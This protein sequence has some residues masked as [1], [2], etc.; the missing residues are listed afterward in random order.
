MNCFL[1]SL[2][3]IIHHCTY[4]KN[5][6][7]CHELRIHNFQ[8]Q[9]YPGCSITVCGFLN[10]QSPSFPFLCTSSFS[11]SYFPCNDSH[12]SMVD[13]QPGPGSAVYNGKCYPT[14]AS[15]YSVEFS[16]ESSKEL[17]I[18]FSGYKKEPRGGWPGGP[19]KEW[20]SAHPC[21][22][23][24]WESQHL[25]QSDCLQCTSP[26]LYQSNWLTSYPMPGFCFVLFKI[27]D[28][29]SQPKDTHKAFVKGRKQG[30]G[31]CSRAS[32][33]NNGIPFCADRIPDTHY[34]F[35]E[36]IYPSVWHQKPY[37][38]Q[39]FV[40]RDEVYTGYGGEKVFLV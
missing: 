3:T 29:S 38:H 34:P 36:H 11:L 37:S 33:A 24:P 19:S 28:S 22:P 30:G 12:G 26:W 21:L 35:W 10:T 20:A 13:K 6:T 14:T 27:S 16:P 25:V 23:S 17:L 1:L 4:L 15:R 39:L 8:S 9:R 32:F 2:K 5:K 31:A 18:M 7:E 40:W